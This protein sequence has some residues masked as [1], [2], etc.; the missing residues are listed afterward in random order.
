MEFQ[1]NEDFAKHYNE[2]RQKE[3]FQ[4]LKTRYGD[5]KLLD[6]KRKADDQSGDDD[7]ASSSSSSSEESD[8][9]WEDQEHEDFLRLYDAL[10]RDDPALKDEEKVWFRPKPDTSEKPQKERNRTVLLK[11]H[12]RDSLLSRGA[13][14]DEDPTM[15]VK[16]TSNFD[17]LKKLQGTDAQTLKQSFLAETE[18]LFSDGN[19]KDEMFSRKESDE[20][21]E[22]PKRPSIDTSHFTF[23]VSGGDEEFLKDYLVNRRWKGREKK[24]VKR[25]VKS[26]V[27]VADDDAL[28][29]R[30]PQM[31][32]GADEPLLTAPEELDADD[33][34]LVK[35]RRF[36]DAWNN[37]DEDL[38]KEYPRTSATRYR[39]EEGDKDFIK[40]YPRRIESSLRQPS[41]AGM[42]RAEK[43]KAR[44]ERKAAEKAA[45]MKD[46]ARFKQLKMA[47][48]AEKLERIRRTCGN[49]T[50]MS[51]ATVTSIA[52][53]GYEPMNEVTEE[54]IECLDNDWDPEAHDRL[55]AKLFDDGYYGA[56][57]PDDGLDE[58]PNIDSDDDDKFAKNLDSGDYDDYLPRQPKVIASH[59]ENSA[60]KCAEKQGDQTLPIIR[61]AKELEKTLGLK[62]KSKGA[63][64]QSLLR[65]ALDRQ[66]PVFSA[67]QYTDF[68]KYFDEFYT[69]DCEDIINGSGPG[70]DVHCRFKYREVKPNDFGLSIEEILNADEKE[71]NRWVSVKTMSAYR[72]EEEEERDLR[73][74]HSSKMLRKKTSLIPSLLTKKQDPSSESAGEA[75][76]AK[77]A[78]AADDEKKLS[79]KA[80]KRLRKK[81]RKAEL[82][83][84]LSAA[85]NNIVEAPVESTEEAVV[86]NEPK[87]PSPDDENANAHR[88]STKRAHEQ[89]EPR[90]TKKQK[91][92]HGVTTSEEIK[93]A[94]HKHFPKKPKLSDERLLAAGID[95]KQFKYMK[96]HVHEKKA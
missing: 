19:D 65:S 67:S 93:P 42:T 54:V 63:H 16:S 52:E 14:N 84:L 21:K 69:L 58:P 28:L 39:F 47:E 37:N 95:P 66:K 9:E 87:N 89:E 46:I 33:E 34:F 57:T 80:L 55:V 40:T 64:R 35:A 94:K 12:A 3:E 78:V 27:G 29:V 17:V 20:Q 30:K 5:V 75:A 13:F 43:R 72:T 10:C 53:N 96:T 44:A 1:I 81:Q 61:A 48:F 85:Q 86:A 49:G 90:K 38:T 56:E 83:S 76:V 74:F 62:K 68:E 91:K 45:K 6:K 36:E 18:R 71:L 4:K 26:S 73:V 77:V 24:D 32:I 31:C 2:Y 23:H 11:D 8:S 51:S 22:G 50:T 60:G 88:G 15:E 92:A 79:K 25:T 70:D 7:S 41:T 59:E 82:S